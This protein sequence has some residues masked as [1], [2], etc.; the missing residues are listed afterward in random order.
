MARRQ[1]FRQEIEIRQVCNNISMM[2]LLQAAISNS[3]W[4]LVPM[5][6]L[7]LDKGV[8]SK[9]NATARVVADRSTSPDAAHQMQPKTRK[10]Q[11]YLD[12]DSIGRSNWVQTLDGFCT[13][14]IV[15]AN[16]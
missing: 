12:L 5:V 16:A 10:C 9:C 2:H 11:K 8:Y 3:N 13:E 7:P 4:R 15:P 14:V 6:R 1:L